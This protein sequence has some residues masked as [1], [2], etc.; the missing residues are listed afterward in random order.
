MNEEKL[1]EE[2]YANFSRLLN[3]QF[4]DYARSEVISNEEAHA[5]FLSSFI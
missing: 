3:I 1:K 4:V 5:R 2:D